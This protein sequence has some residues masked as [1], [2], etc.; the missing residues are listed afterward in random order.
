MTGQALK[1]WRERRGWSLREL[2]E[3]VGVSAAQLS[4]YENDEAGPPLTV[5][6]ACAALALGVQN[7]DFADQ[8]VVEWRERRALDAAPR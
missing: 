8:V 3:R 2:G 7:Y 4:R 1:A 5:R 6:L